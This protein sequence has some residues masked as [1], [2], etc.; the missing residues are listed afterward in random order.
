MNNYKYKYFIYIISSSNNIWKDEIIYI[1][2]HLRI[3]LN[4]LII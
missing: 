2:I 3:I 1:N 4:I